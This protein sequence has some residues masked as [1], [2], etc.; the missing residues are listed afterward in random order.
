MGCLRAGH[1]IVTLNPIVRIFLGVR[2]GM[3]VELGIMQFLSH[4]IIPC[5]L[6]VLKRV[7]GSDGSR[8]GALKVSARPVPAVR[9]ALPHGST[10]SEE[11]RVGK[12]CVSMCRSRWSL[13]P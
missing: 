1:R 3:F 10:R 2:T 4:S 13:Y 9:Q 8:A 6:F 5:S 11:R 12:E 7:L